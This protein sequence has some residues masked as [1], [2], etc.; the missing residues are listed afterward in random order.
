MLA[1]IDSYNVFP[2]SGPNDCPFLLLDGHPSRTMLPFLAYI[3]NPETKWK[4]CFGVP[5]G[6]HIWQPADSSEINGCFKMTLQRTKDEYLKSKLG[7]D[8]SFAQTD[9]IPIL[10]KSWQNSIGNKEKARKAILNRGWLALNYALVDDDRLLGN[11]KQSKRIM[12]RRQPLMDVSNLPNELNK[13]GEFYNSVCDTLFRDE[14]QAKARKR[15]YEEK[16]K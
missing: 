15:K 5:Y 13:T 2:R 11:E 14:A 4:T 7:S 6:T 9:V 3:N 10:N 1:T 8:K 16:Q 12:R